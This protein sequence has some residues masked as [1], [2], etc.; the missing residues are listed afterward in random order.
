M[1][2]LF[3][4]GVK[5]KRNEARAAG[6][7]TSRKFSIVHKIFLLALVVQICAAGSLKA[8]LAPFTWNN[9]GN[10]SDPN[11]NPSI[12]STFYTDDTKAQVT[13]SGITGNS[14]TGFTI[15]LDLSS[16]AVNAT[17]GTTWTA[18]SN[19]PGTLFSSGD[20]IMV[21]D[22]GFATTN[23][24]NYDFGTVQSYSYSSGIGTLVVQSPYYNSASSGWHLSGTL[25]AGEVLKIHQYNNVTINSGGVVTCDAW[26]G[27]IG[28]VVMFDAAGTLTFNWSGG[29]PPQI[30]AS[31]MG[32]PGGSGGVEDNTPVSP[33]TNGYGASGLAY[34]GD[35]GNATIGTVS[36][37]FVTLNGDAMYDCSAALVKGG[38]AGSHSSFEGTRHD[39]SFT[40]FNP[41]VY[42]SITGPFALFIGNGGGGGQ[43]GEDA[44]YGGW[45]GGGGGSGGGNPG[46]PGSSSVPG[47][48]TSGAYGGKGGDGAAGGGIVYIRAWVINNNT[49]SGTLKLIVSDGNDADPVSGNGEAGYGI[50]GNGSD[51]GAGGNG[52]ADC[53][54]I[55]YP[56]GAGGKGGI[57]GPAASGGGGG[58][59]GDA[60]TIW[61]IYGSG[62]SNN[63]IATNMELNGG[64][65]GSG[66]AGGGTNGTNGAD[67]AFGSQ[68]P[69]CPCTCGAH[70]ADVYNNL[71]YA[72]DC[73]AA[74]AILGEMNM[75][76]YP[77][78][79]NIYWNSTNSNIGAERYSFPSNYFAA[80]ETT[81]VINGCTGSSVYLVKTH[82]CDMDPFNYYFDN[83]TTYYPA[84]TSATY[85]E[86]GSGGSDGYYLIGSNTLYSD[87]TMTPPPVSQAAVCITP[88]PGGGG[89]NGGQFGSSGLDGTHGNGKSPI[90]DTDD[91]TPTTTNY[92]FAPEKTKI[93]SRQLDHLITLFP[94]PATDNINVQ[95][96]VENGGI[97]PITIIDIQ[98]KHLLDVVVNANKGQQS[99]SMDVSFL[100]KGSYLFCVQHDN[101][102]EKAQFVR[103]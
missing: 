74:F 53:S 91:Q 84:T 61:V 57:G 98:G 3:K 73:D 52:Y 78:S 58:A 30:T 5:Q 63:L 59:G 41:S 96:Y 62:G 33:G 31:G 67:G 92:V 71:D 50:G 36:S 90:P 94:N 38:K 47:A 7:K 2:A 39:G 10:G 25:N 51:G 49:G 44:E 86:W 20:R 16:Y 11:T 24:Q 83:F 75:P 85:T 99:L 89:G 60:G 34:G 48:P 54:T 64:D 17:T 26:N 14:S 46:Y 45:G 22:M 68:P 95:F 21:I 69:L 15:T 13:G 87:N 40:Q 42:T 65:K 55:A 35:G 27:N 8:Q 28:G 18:S 103:Q 4:S 82:E 100:A 29:A 81:S 6:R 97:T 79:G 102:L 43:G 1:Q 101:R 23:S 37:P 9:F 56:A 76:A 32:G 12:S 88:L 72:C 77:V 19:S 70:Y 80:T 93:D 66:G